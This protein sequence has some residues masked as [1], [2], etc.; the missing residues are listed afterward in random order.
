MHSLS[1]IPLLFGTALATSA[2]KPA[3]TACPSGSLTV[4]DANGQLADAEETYRVGRKAAADKSLVAWLDARSAGLGSSASN[5]PTLALS[6]SGGGW[7]SLLVGAGVMQGLD[8]RDSN[9]STSGLLQAMTYTI[10]VSGGAWLV[11]SW[12]GNNFPTVTSLKNDLWSEAFAHGLEAPGGW[13]TL[14][15]Y[16]RITADV[17]A[18]DV[19]GYPTSL[20][21]AW[22]RLLSYQ[23]LPGGNGGV[24][25]RLSDVAGYSGMA[26]FTAPMPIINAM[27]VDTVAGYCSP[28]DNSTVWEFTPFEFGSW[29]DDIASFI[30][31]EYL[32]TAP[33]DAR[34]T[35]GFD[36][37]GFILGSSSNLFGYE[38]CVAD[39]TLFSATNPVPGAIQE[40]VETLH[41]IGSGLYFGRFPNPFRGHNGTGEEP[42][43]AFLSD[44]LYMV[45]GGL[46]AH[47]DPVVPL[48]ETARNVSVILLS[49][50]SAD[51]ARNFP[52]GENLIDAYDYARN[53]PRVAGR[54]PAVPDQ[55]TFAALG[56]AKKAVFFG[57]HQAGTAT[58]VYLPNVNYTYASGT[59]TAKFQYDAD[60]TGGIIANG[61]QVASQDGD[62]GWGLCLACGIMMKEDVELPGGCDACFEQY[63]WVSDVVMSAVADIE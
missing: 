26:E 21:D 37:L 15:N 47:N 19:A 54:M 48:L 39:N 8:D 27:G 22:S 10:G 12:A 36:N 34:C 32:G 60:E 63:C 62:E 29:D 14:T 24:A 18:K 30:P 53:V 58:I 38:A 49:D 2:Y 35:T 13:E 41:D 5:L 50:S 46:G 42:P 1:L 43:G 25:V 3:T 17:L 45:D 61:V 20:T 52:T 9:V 28:E 44:E 40:F 59:A 56:L 4:R 57:C 55:A 31:T 7:R 6:I 23:L 51:D 33:G 16:A 11:S